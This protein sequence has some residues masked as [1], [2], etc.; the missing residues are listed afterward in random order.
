L[1]VDGVVLLG[2]VINLDLGLVLYREEAN[3]RKVETKFKHG[4]DAINHHG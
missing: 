4:I 3:T 1:I 2:G